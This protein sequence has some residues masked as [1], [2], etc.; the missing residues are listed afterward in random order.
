MKILFIC[1]SLEDG[2]DGVGDYSRRLASELIKNGHNVSILALYD[3]YVAVVKNEFQQSGENIIPVLRI[4]SHENSKARFKSAAQYISEYNPEWLSLQYVPYSFQNKGLP[5]MLVNRLRKISVGRKWHIMFHELWVEPINNKRRLLGF[6]QKKIIKKLHDN[7][8]PQVT[9]TS[10]PIYKKRLN[11][12]GIDSDALNLFSNI[13]KVS[14]TI[15][16]ENLN[17]DVSNEIVKI[18]FFSQISYRKEVFVF[19]DQL[20]DNLRIKLLEFEIVLLGGN[21]ISMKDFSLKLEENTKLACRIHR[22]GHLNNEQISLVLQEC[23]LGITTVPRH[24]L[25]KS[26]SVLA[27]LAHGVPV[28]A[29]YIEKNHDSNDIGF[30]DLSIA[31]RILLKPDFDNLKFINKNK[32]IDASFFSLKIIADKFIIDLTN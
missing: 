23:H 24:F 1:G 32:V 26:G 17:I 11:S 22:T 30:F 9:H 21:E 5:F 7:L 20:I 15:E 18:C 8:L 6:L 13:A 4:P 27:F 14:R 10:V 28:A 2:R 12:I 16:G 19:L 31:D 29:P 3:K 25:G